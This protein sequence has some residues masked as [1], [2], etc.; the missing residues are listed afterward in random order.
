MKHSTKACNPEGLQEKELSAREQWE[1]P[2][3]NRYKPRHR[4]QLSSDEID[5]IVLAYDVGHKKQAEVAKQFRIKE[6][7][8]NRL[9]NESRKQPEK[10]RDLKLKEKEAARNS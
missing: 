4:S 10:Q 3:G 5:N 8:V 1:K 7:L 2:A 9:V 6:I